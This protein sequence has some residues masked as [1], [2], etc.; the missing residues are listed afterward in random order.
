MQIFTDGG[1]IDLLF[2]EGGTGVG[3]STSVG[4]AV[5]IL[6]SFDEQ[7]GRATVVAFR[8]NSVCKSIPNEQ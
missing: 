7:I 4:P 5:D 8:R 3:G 1:Q 2:Q 6:Q